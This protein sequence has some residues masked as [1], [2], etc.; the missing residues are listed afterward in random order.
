MVRMRFQWGVSSAAGTLLEGDN[1]MKHISRAAPLT[2][3]SLFYCAAMF[4][5]AVAQTIQDS[6]VIS[7]FLAVNSNGLLDK[8]HDS[9]DWIE[10][11]NPTGQ[12]I[13]LDGWYLTDNMRNLDKW[14]FPPVSIAPGGYLVVFASGKDIREP[15]GELHTSFSLQAAG[16]SVALVQPDGVTVAHAYVDYPPQVVDISYGLS[17][18]GVVSQTETVLLAEGADAR[19]LVPTN[20]SLGLTW[21]LAS[22]SDAA[23][24]AGKT[25][26]GYD[27]AGLIQLDVGA[28]MNVNQTVYARMAFDVADVTQIDKL[29]LRLKYEDGFVAYLN[30]VEVARDNAPAA[31]SLM[32]NSGAL[33][34]R[35]DNLA[36]DAVEFDL[37]A[38]KAILFKGRNVLAVHGLN[39]SLASSDLLILPQLVA[40][41]TETLDLSEVM[42]GHLLRPT[43]RAANQSSLVQIGP[44]IRHVT[45]NPPPPAPGQDLVIAAQVSENLAPV[46][47]VNLICRVNFLTDNR[48]IPSGGLTM[49]DDGK[50]KDA[51]ADDGIYTAVI[52]AQN[53]APGD[54]V[55]W[56]VRA[57]DTGGNVSRDP[58]F[59]NPNDSP[60]YYGTVVQDPAIHSSLPVFQWFVKNVGASE[61]RST[62]RASVYYNG[63]F[64]DNIGMHIRGGSTAGAP[65][66]HFKFHFNHGYKFRYSDDSPTVN[67][68]NLNSTYSD[69]AYLRQ[70]MA[71]EAY[72]WCGCPGSESFPVR[73]ERNGDFY[74]VQI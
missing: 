22:F 56:Y 46:R 32:W 38:R 43:P 60:E 5:I 26:I 71:F 2:A 74:G 44:A 21:T 62:T 73:A 42:E 6:P 52:P 14:E 19:A 30:G 18:D 69:K 27:Y 58:L 39:S 48:F 59:A 36:V 57:E 55:C 28:M 7:E 51:T 63:E 1:T 67:E 20:G 64:Y 50:G 29:V 3:M 11:Y 70:N 24:R 72:D 53:Y 41:E 47:S 17:S 34:N 65:K 13:D 45:E 12:A 10:I 37:T 4:A 15:G 68:I 33:A 31:A 16:E 54:M 35:E 66:K 9:S 8:D 61:G 49:L 40:I 25:G 23:W